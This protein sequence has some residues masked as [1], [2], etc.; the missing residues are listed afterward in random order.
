MAHA[1]V[2]WPFTTDA[3]V[4]PQLIPCGIC[5]GQNDIEMIS[6]SS[7]SAFRSQYHSTNAS[8]SLTLSE[9]Y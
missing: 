4:Q 7:T 3:R 9:R 6:Y 5:G 2:L 1:F 8:Y